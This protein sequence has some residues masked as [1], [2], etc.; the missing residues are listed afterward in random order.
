[1]FNND[2]LDVMIKDVNDGYGALLRSYLLLEKIQD[3]DL[4]LKYKQ[5][6][7]VVKKELKM[8]EVIIKNELKRRFKESSVVD[9][10]YAKIL[11]ELNKN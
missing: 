4:Q 9:I 6:L 3:K 1:M 11:K 2:E 8:L 5:D 7:V 10:K